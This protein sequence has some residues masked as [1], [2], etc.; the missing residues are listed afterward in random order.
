[1]KRVEWLPSAERIKALLAVVYGVGIPLLFWANT[2]SSLALY[3]LLAVVVP[4][5]LL[6]VSRALARG[7][8]RATL[9]TVSLLTT[10]AFGVS[11]LIGIIITPFSAYKLWFEA[12]A[13]GTGTGTVSNL[14]TLLSA[15]F[16]TSLGATF[17]SMGF[18]WPLLLS[19]AFVSALVAVILQVTPLYV[20]TLLAGLACVGYL[21]FREREGSYRIRRA[22]YAGGLFAAVLLS[23]TLLSGSRAATGR[24][25]IRNCA[26]T[27]PTRCPSSPCCTAFPATATPFRSAPWAARPCSRRCRSSASRRTWTVRCT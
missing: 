16:S 2:Q 4:M 5:T 27:C 15:F 7:A 12:M 14:F 23:A 10:A 21:L 8:L 20:L 25:C 24:P 11:V 19:A 17:I 18:V 3:L 13:E 22:V 9:S 6:H 1:M 26:S